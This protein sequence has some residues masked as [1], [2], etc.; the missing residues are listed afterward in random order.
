MNLLRFLARLTYRRRWFVLGGFAAL[1]A[2]AAAYGAGA[3]RFL[4]GGGF[5][6]PESESARA[7]RVLE[8]E[9]GIRDPDVVLV[10]SHE[11]ASFRDPEFAGP[12]SAVL[13]RVAEQEGVRRVQ[14]P[15]A[16]G[17][18]ALVARDGRAVLVTIEL[19][20]N[21]AE[22][23]RTFDRIEPLLTADGLQ[24][25][26]GG[27]LPLE[28]EAQRDAERDL[29]RGEMITIPIV[30]VLL[31]LFFRGV[32]AAAL[33]LSIG[34]F[35][36]GAALACVRLLAHVTDVSTF[37]MNIVTFIG[38]GVA[39]DYS[40]FVTSRF[41]EELAAG[42]SVPAALEHTMQKAGRTVAYSGL[43]VAVSLLGMLAFPV[44]L[45]RSV[46]I[47][48]ALVVA[49]AVVATL[50]F[51]PAALAALGHRIEWLRIGGPRLEAHG[52]RLWRRVASLSMRA[53]VVVTVVTSATLLLL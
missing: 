21:E 32:V 33:P 52:R 37:A 1:L 50:T 5:T 45:L 26:I 24:L 40:L 13:S 48:G 36:I 4:A 7:A 29:R 49:M 19:A 16:P 47:S 15:Y 46:A 6:D 14:S 27:S 35:A 39:V 12:L 17:G 43:V 8:E 30:A 25:R 2:A 10:Y 34:M 44:V 3:S 51:L 20:G 22:R 23:M 42:L 18:E 31:I 53:P 28:R 9:L 11:R 38:L 41:R